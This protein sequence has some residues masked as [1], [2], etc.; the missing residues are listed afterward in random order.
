MEKRYEDKASKW[1]KSES[2]TSKEP[3]IIDHNIEDIIIKVHK[4]LMEDNYAQIGAQV[5]A[6]KLKNLGI[7]IYP[8]FPSSTA[9]SNAMI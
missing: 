4:E 8:H 6:W 3:N 9:K 5:I 1:Y 2:R 7:K